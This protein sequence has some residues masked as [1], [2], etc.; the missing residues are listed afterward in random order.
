M[1]K[2][3]LNKLVRDKLK[4]VYVKLDQ[5]AT[6]RELDDEQYKQELLKKIKEEVDELAQ[7]ALGDQATEL[8]DIMQVLQDFMTMHSISPKVVEKLR[9]DKL[10]Q[11]GGF[12]GRTFVKSLELKNDDVWVKYY[13]AEPKKY[14]E[15]P[16]LRA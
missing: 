4:D 12:A 15:L 9:Q 8:A 14:E 6:Y 10:C 3:L 1:P 7:A 5:S 2:F 13:R 11:K 16:D